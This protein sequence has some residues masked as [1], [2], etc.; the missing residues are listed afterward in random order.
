M[1]TTR[2]G[3]RVVVRYCLCGEWDLCF[4]G[5]VF[6]ICRSSYW[7]FKTWINHYSLWSLSRSA[8]EVNHALSFPGMYFG[9]QVKHRPR[10]PEG[11]GISWLPTTDIKLEFVWDSEGGRGSLGVHVYGTGEGRR[12]VKPIFPGWPTVREDQLV[13]DHSCVITLNQCFHH[14]LLFPSFLLTRDTL[15][16]RDFVLFTLSPHHRWRAGTCSPNE[17][18][19]VQNDIWARKTLVHTQWDKSSSL[20]SLPLQR[21][22]NNN[23]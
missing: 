19:Q 17:H 15:K 4:S 20:L 5:T 21:T 23:H 1:L 6:D 2:S 3:E 14:W 13:P 10:M 8:R 11:L 9:I 7:S 12:V 16:S 18:T 22:Q